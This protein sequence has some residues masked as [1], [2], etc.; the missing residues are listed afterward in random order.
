MR[1]RLPQPR[2]ALDARVLRSA[3]KCDIHKQP[4]VREYNDESYHEDS[5]SVVTYVSV[6]LFGFLIDASGPLFAHELC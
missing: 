3:H 1:I 6:L 4:E 5:Q 2:R